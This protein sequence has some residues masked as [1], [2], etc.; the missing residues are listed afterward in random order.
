MKGV[1]EGGY[2]GFVDRSEFFTGD[3][4]PTF[5]QAMNA[6]FNISYSEDRINSVSSPR[7]TKTDARFEEMFNDPELQLP[8]EVNGQNMVQQYNG[9]LDNE[10]RHKQ[11][12]AMRAE[13]DWTTKALDPKFDL[14]FGTQWRA[15][16]MTQDAIENSGNKYKSDKMLL[17]E[18]YQDM[19]QVRE[20]NQPILDAY[21][22]WFAPVLGDVGA[23][24]TD[25][26]NLATIPFGAAGWIKGAGIISN[27]LRVGGT[28][29]L[30]GAYTQATTEA[31]TTIDVKQEL[32][33]DYGWHQASQNVVVSGLGGFALGAMGAGGFKLAGDFVTALKKGRADAQEKIDTGQVGRTDEVD[34]AMNAVDD[35]IAVTEQAPARSTPEQL[36][37]FYAEYIEAAMQLRKDADSFD[38]PLESLKTDYIAEQQ[39]IVD[40]HMTSKEISGANKRIRK[41]KKNADANASQ[42][43]DLEARIS[44]AT[45]SAKA[46]KARS[47]IGRAGQ[48][49]FDDDVRARYDSYEKTYQYD[50]AEA[51]RFLRDQLKDPAYATQKTA[52]RVA[53]EQPAA[54]VARVAEQPA[55]APNLA[56]PLPSTDDIMYTRYFNETDRQADLDLMDRYENNLADG[57][58]K[59]PQVVGND[60]YG[61]VIGEVMSAKKIANDLEADTEILNKVALCMRGGA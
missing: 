45:D 52:R 11:F 60:K 51:E 27:I 32:G 47:N 20:D 50:A 42:I 16:N 54:P 44:R 57:D 5:T 40:A 48:G 25:P 56:K 12:Q 59:V 31:V 28:E 41:L 53:A 10:K 33:D 61:N 19:Q 35:L 8:R 21:D 15:Y 37:A 14:A 46:N 49:L 36:D 6:R 43:L 23:A 58:F 30:I 34:A 3:I 38:R 22:G 24:F 17:D 2:Q 9:V 39:I 1:F 18:V 26:L 4:D 7:T 29:G 55:P 13:E